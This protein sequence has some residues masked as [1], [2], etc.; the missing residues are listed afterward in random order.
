MATTPRL[1]RE[2]PSAAWEV[3]VLRD[4]GAAQVAASAVREAMWEYAGIDRSARGLR[5][6]LA[7][8]D[9]IESRL[10]VGATEE[11][12]LVE[13]GRLIASAALHRK[14]SRGG[15]FRSD[16]PT[17]KRTWEGRHIVW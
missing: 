1:D 10:P 7:R 12:N 6:C 8:L 9:D 17:A 13:T 4:R 11:L 2:P 3:P 15:H 14:E 16:Y 5:T